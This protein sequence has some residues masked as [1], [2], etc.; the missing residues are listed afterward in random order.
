MGA[1]IALLSLP[2]PD[3]LAVI[4][5]SPYAHL[6]G[7]LRSFVH[8]QLMEISKNWSAPLRPLR[9]T[10][11]ALSWA[12]VATSR[13]V[14]RLRYGHRLIARPASGL[15]HWHARANALPDRH[16][17]Q[18]EDYPAGSNRGPGERRN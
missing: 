14:F 17:T 15:R 6:D 5:D 9:A 18:P 11:P 2:H 4:A 10:I 16:I 12:T 7:I 1:S 13:I 3:V 8:W